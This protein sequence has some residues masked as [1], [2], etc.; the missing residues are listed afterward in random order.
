[1]VVFDRLREHDDLAC[2]ARRQR[3]ASLRRA[4]AGQRPKHP[5]KPSDFHPQSCAM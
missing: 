1:M 5:A 4:Y 2:A 3:K